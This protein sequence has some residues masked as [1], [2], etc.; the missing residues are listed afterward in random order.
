MKHWLEDSCLQTIYSA[1]S[2]QKVKGIS[3][4][5]GTISDYYSL[6]LVYRSLIGLFWGEGEIQVSF[7]SAA[8]SYGKYIHI[9]IVSIKYIF[10]QHIYKT[11]PSLLPLLPLMATL[12][13]VLKPSSLCLHDAVKWQAFPQYYVR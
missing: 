4:L 3:A 1:S 12:Y 11:D 2:I 13:H 6:W 9:W 5:I 7:A 8:V 10:I